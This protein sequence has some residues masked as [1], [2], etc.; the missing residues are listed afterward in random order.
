MISSTYEFVGVGLNLMIP[1]TCTKIN[2]RFRF[3]QPLGIIGKAT[4]WTREIKDL[5]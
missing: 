2:L 1:Q 5:R 4:T 3:V